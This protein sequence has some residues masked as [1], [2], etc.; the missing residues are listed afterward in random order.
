MAAKFYFLQASRYTS[1][2]C[3]WLSSL[4][5]NVFHS[6]H[7]QN[8][9]LVNKYKYYLKAQKFNSLKQ[10]F[11]LFSSF[12]FSSFYLS[13]PFYPASSFDHDQHHLVF[14]LKINTPEF[15]TVSNVTSYQTWCSKTFQKF[16]LTPD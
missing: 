12:S 10:K 14:Q 13:R 15:N 6:D 16:T 7:V 1:V 5:L 2:W 11:I 9:P 4:D 3:L 8:R